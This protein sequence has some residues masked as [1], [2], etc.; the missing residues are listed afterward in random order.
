MNSVSFPL[1]Y[2]LIPFGLFLL[3]CLAYHVFILYDLLR[4]G[5]Y[6]PFL[7]MV[8]TIFTAGSLVILA[9]SLSRLA[10]YTWTH[11]VT[12][13]SILNPTPNLFP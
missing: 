13:T 1:A 7:Y 3:G 10:P 5:V 11:V 2:L 4:F 12:P 9:V 8:V 6:G